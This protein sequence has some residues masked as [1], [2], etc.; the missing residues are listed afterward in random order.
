MKHGLKVGVNKGVLAP[1]ELA[2][3]LEAPSRLEI[4][5]I[6]LDKVDYQ[7]D[8]LLATKLRMS[9]SN[10]IMAEGGIGAA[11]CQNIFERKFKEFA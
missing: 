5:R 11:H 3:L 1:S 6:R 10:T 9:D 8:V 2:D 4:N 7:T